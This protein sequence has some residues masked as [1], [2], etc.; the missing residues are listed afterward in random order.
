MNI[1]IIGA[2]GF[3]GS[4][5]LNVLSKTGQQIS[6]LTRSPLKHDLG[7]LHFIGD[8]GD[9][10]VIDLATKNIDVIYHLATATHPAISNQNINHE[11][12]EN[13]QKLLVVLESCIKNKVKKIIY[14]SSAGAI[15]GIPKNVPI[16]ENHETN[17]ISPYG[18][19]KL[20]AEKYLHYYHHHYNLDYSAIRLTNPYGQGQDFQKGLGAITTF[21][22]K[23]NKNE[24]IDIYGDGMV[25]RDY[26]YIEDVITALCKLYEKNSIHKVFNL[27]IGKGVTLLELLNIIEKKMNKKFIINFHSKRAN[28]VP[29]NTVDINLLSKEYN[30]NPAFTIEEGID[31]YLTY[32]KSKE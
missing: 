10:K 22:N 32:L 28:D 29:D 4:N 20:L 21:I 19:G 7:S 6:T 14:L 2:N 13:A 12:M 26:I 8:L 15:Y 30:F 27:G 1:L 16:K 31:K 24:A 5:L 18:I 25:R 3:V 23:L 11:I 9:E 17:P